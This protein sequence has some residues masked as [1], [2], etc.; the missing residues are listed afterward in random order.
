MIQRGNGVGEELREESEGQ[1]G[2]GSG[3][4]RAVDPSTK[5][6]PP[7]RPG[8]GTPESIPIGFPVGPGEFRQLK[9]EAEEAKQPPDNQQCVPAQQDTAREED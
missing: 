1:S 6:P 3:A 9:E 7:V 5:E 8:V 2:S 4:G